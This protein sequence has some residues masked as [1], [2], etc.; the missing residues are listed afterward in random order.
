VKARWIAPAALCFAS[1]IVLGARESLAVFTVEVGID[2][3]R[4]C[5]PEH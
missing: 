2:A 4:Q 1:T 5:F 3:A